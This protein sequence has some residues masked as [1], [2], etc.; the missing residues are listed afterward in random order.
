MFYLLLNKEIFLKRL[1]KYLILYC[2]KN[3]IPLF[4][5]TIF[6]LKLAGN[7]PILNLNKSEDNRIISNIYV[8]QYPTE[9]Q[10]ESR[11]FVVITAKTYNLLRNTA[12]ASQYD[13]KRSQS[14]SPTSSVFPSMRRFSDMPCA[15][16]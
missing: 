2:T 12:K 8:N 7:S 13:R 5:C 10:G 16:N 3:R 6:F 14:G 15:G 11:N 4:Y 9:V 1:Y